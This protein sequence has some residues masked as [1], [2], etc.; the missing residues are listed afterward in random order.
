MLI[1]FLLPFVAWYC[2]CSVW[3]VIV[4]LPLLMDVFVLFFDAIARNSYGKKF[5]SFFDDKNFTY[6]RVVGH[7]SIKI[8]HGQFEKLVCFGFCHYLR[9]ANTI[10][11]DC[12]AACIYAKLMQ[13]ENLNQHATLIF[14]TR[15]LGFCAQVL[16][17]VEHQT[18]DCT[19]VHI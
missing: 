6:T 1:A 16:N 14:H 10:D 7:N 15:I 13:N 8:S 18:V 17:D 9:V 5:G 3:C 2:Y 4:N 11:M 19:A 12:I